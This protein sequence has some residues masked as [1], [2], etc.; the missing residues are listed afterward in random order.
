M[1]VSCCLL[2]F[3]RAPVNSPAMRLREFGRRALITIRAPHAPLDFMHGVPGRLQAPRASMASGA[4]R[5]LEA[6]RLAR[7]ARGFWHCVQLQT[8]ASCAFASPG[9]VRKMKSGRRASPVV[10]ALCSNAGPGRLHLHDLERC[11]P[12]AIRAP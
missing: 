8:Q 9:A 7:H 3:R 4:V 2:G 6:V 11:A 1:A 5:R 12:I 10:P